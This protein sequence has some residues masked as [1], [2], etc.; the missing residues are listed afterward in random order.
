MELE[1]SIPRTQEPAISPYP[2]ATESSPPPMSLTSILI[3][4]CHLRLDPPSRLVL[5]DSSTVILHAFLTSLC[6]PPISTSSSSSS[7]NIQLIVE[8][9]KLPTVNFSLSEYYFLPLSLSLSVSL[10]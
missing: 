9:M 8:I 3:L 5:S 4:S 1:R 10:S 6:P 2:E 7:N